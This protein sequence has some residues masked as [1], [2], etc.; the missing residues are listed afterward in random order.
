VVFHNFQGLVLLRIMVTI[1]LT[2]IMEPLRQDQWWISIWMVQQTRLPLQT[3]WTPKVRGQD[4]KCRATPPTT[5]QPSLS[6]DLQWTIMGLSSRIIMEVETI[7][8]LS[9]QL[10]PIIMPLHSILSKITC[11]TF[12]RIK[13]AETLISFQQLNRT[14]L[15][16][17]GFKCPLF[18]VC[19][20]QRGRLTS[21][22]LSNSRVGNSSNSLQLNN[23]DSQT[24]H[25]RYNS[26]IHHHHSNQILLHNKITLHLYNLMLHLLYSNSRMGKVGIK[27]NKWM[28]GRQHQLTVVMLEINLS[29]Q[30]DRFHK[31]MLD[32]QTTQEQTSCN[33]KMNNL[34][35]H[36]VSSLHLNPAWSPHKILGLLPSAQI[37]VH[38]LKLSSQGEPR[39][40]N[41]LI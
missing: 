31:L 1:K 28:M 41:H 40:L 19:N 5:L 6:L 3:Q 38:R 24:I 21:L 32:L 9:R 7:I 17:P 22:G 15:H 14:H 18:R 12:N 10:I 37:W 27:S 13:M 25:L 39:H 35:N 30:M 29:S 26:K 11:L 34:T 4:F 36:Q 16:N 8:I 23:W 33:N 2:T 20:R